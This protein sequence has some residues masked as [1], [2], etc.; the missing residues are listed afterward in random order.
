MKPA[1]TITY[2]YWKLV[3]T[4]MFIFLARVVATSECLSFTWIFT[5]TLGPNRVSEFCCYVSIV[6]QLTLLI[7]LFWALWQWASACKDGR[8]DL[9][10]CRQPFLVLDW[11]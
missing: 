7:W 3:Y 4:G 6:F 2:W 9:L 5:G 10:W 1:T 8:I 11:F